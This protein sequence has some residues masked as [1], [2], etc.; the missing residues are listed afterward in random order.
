MP[1]PCPRAAVAAD[2]GA[3]IE[4]SPAPASWTQRYPPQV[5]AL[6]LAIWL[7]RH[8]WEGIWHDGTVY[9][10]L[11]LHWMQ[12]QVF[13]H[14]LFFQYGSQAGYTV[15]T[16]LYATAIA[17][18][19]LYGGTLT[20]LVCSYAAWAAAAAYLLR[21]FA[22]GR[23]F[24]LGMVIVFA[25]PNDYG[26][27][28]DVLHL[29]ESF[30]T[31]RPF[32]EAL[33]MTSLAFVLRGKWP[34]AV[35]AALLACLLHP[36]MGL[37]GGGSLLIYGGWTRPWRMAL[38]LAAGA[39]AVS[40]AAWLGGAPFDRL[41]QQ[42][43]ER[44][45]AQIQQA[46]YMVAWSAWRGTEWVSRTVLAFSLVLTGALLA[47]GGLRRMLAS[48]ALTGAIGLVATWLGTGVYHNV[49]VMQLQPWRALWLVQLAALCA[50]P[51]LAASCW[52]RGGLYRMLLLA[53]FLAYLA[54]DSVGGGLGAAAGLTLWIVRWRLSSTALPRPWLMAS[55]AV[56]STA[57][58]AAWWASALALA[59]G[60]VGLMSET[61][62]PHPHLYLLC[63]VVLKRGAGAAMAL[64]LFGLLPAGGGPRAERGQMAVFGV[65]MAILL[66]AAITIDRRQASNTYRDPATVA[67]IRSR[68]LPLIGPSA[69]VYWE[70]DVWTT[71]F[72]LQRAGYAS[73]P[74]LVGMVFSRG[75]AIEGARRLE[76]LR[77]LGVSD[78]VADEDGK[79]RHHKILNLPAPSFAG[80]VH[81]CH[82]P[83]LDFVVLTRRYQD[84]VVQQAAD[85]RHGQDFYLYDCALLR[86]RYADP[87]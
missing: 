19:G 61:T 2:G 37:A 43:D 58:L 50:L 29:N 16:P 1:A 12:P 25:L 63:W 24:W 74:Q 27:I 56:M 20:L 87:L 54:R 60:W 71:W 10:A 51:W 86:G 83:L 5:L 31:P 22:H 9:A 32:A 23:Y 70:D 6:L 40:A 47:E 82:D 64:A 52:P 72:V 85:L 84:G 68:F 26:P 55:T 3:H 73:Y 11:A 35:L 49:L 28:Q 78:A 39:A 81:V 33:V 4:A 75:T 17:A 42:M 65:L 36:L 46:A 79:R 62:L 18:L 13:G 53:L 66:T 69:N 21:F 80:L 76:R 8:P 44:W 45:Y 77:A 67:D 14:D 30:L 59:S 57:V 41:L 48:I 15:F 38:V 7:W 34:L